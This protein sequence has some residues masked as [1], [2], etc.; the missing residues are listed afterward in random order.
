VECHRAG[1]IA[2]FA[3]TNYA[4]VAGWADTI[5]EVI[6]DGRMPPWHANPKHGKFAN[7]RK[8]TDNEKQLI[9]QWVKNGTPE[10]DPKDL[11]KPKSYVSGWQLPREP[12]YV[13]PLTSKPHKVP[14]QG[15][16]KYVHFIVGTS[17]KED[18]W[19]EWA[20]IVPG[21]KSVVHHVLCWAVAPGKIKEM[22]AAVGEGGAGFLAGYVPGQTAYTYPKGMA[23]RLPAGATLVFQV[24]YT[25]IG[26]AQ[27]DQSKIGLIFADPKT[28][29]HEVKTVNVLNRSFSIPPGN[30]SYKVE[31]VSKKSLPEAILLG[32]MPHMHL[33]GKSFQYTLQYP[34]GKKEIMLDVPHYDFN[35]QTAYRLA[36]PLKLPAGTKMH[37]VAH[38]NNSEGNLNNPDPKSLVRWGPQTWQ[39][40]MIGYFDLAVPVSKAKDLNLDGN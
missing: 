40:M 5:V 22:A 10:G 36:E 1:E 19:V 38:F 24:H 32:F 9:A 30:A 17:F 13:A 16:I 34:D 6:E 3:L 20:Q 12:D 27:E 26:T 11:P 18:R 21:N 25:P 4:E 31:A 23:K 28:V 33:R 37:C 29:T 2:P 39:E 35:W 14:A 15:V 8:L 7:E